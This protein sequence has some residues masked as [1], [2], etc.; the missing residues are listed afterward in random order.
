LSELNARQVPFNEGAR[1]GDRFLYQ[2]NYVERGVEHIAGHFGADMAKA[3]FDLEARDDLWYGPFESQYG[4]HL[5]M[6]AHRSPGHRPQLSEIYEQVKQD[7]YQVYIREK[8][9]AIIRDIIDAYKVSVTYQPALQDTAGTDQTK[10]AG[11]DSNAVAYETLPTGS[12]AE[13][14]E[15]RVP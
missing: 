9:E 7:V 15:R 2:V 3:V 14:T 5:V 13:K 8:N 4:F 12:L 10:T 6:V 1:Q 11:R